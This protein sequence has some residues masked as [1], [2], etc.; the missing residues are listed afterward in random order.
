[1]IVVVR[2]ATPTLPETG[3]VMPDMT[4]E[5]QRM[6]HSFPRL[7]RTAELGMMSTVLNVFS[8][9]SAAQADIIVHDLMETLAYHHT[10]L[11]NRE[12]F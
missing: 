5:M 12:P 2:T 11:T 7:W 4:P 3:I 9:M 6:K 8:E 10:E 1:M